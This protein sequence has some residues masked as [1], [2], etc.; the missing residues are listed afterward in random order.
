VILRAR[1]L[2]P[3][4]APPV[5]DGAVLISGDHIRFAGPWEDLRPHATGS[6]T[7]LGEVAL[8]PGLINA[9]C[10]LDYTHLAGQLKPTA[11][12]PDWIKAI[13]AAKSA[14]GIGEFSNSWLAGARQLLESG[15]TTVVNIES[16][17]ELLESCRP[18]TP[19]RVWSF[20]E[21]TGVRS[22]LPAA[23]IVGQRESL[24]KGQS[25]GRGGFG[26]SPHAPYSTSP[27]LLRCAAVIAR[28]HGWP[29]STHVA[30]SQA[31][32]DMFMYR[33]G[34]MFD[35]LESQRPMDD[36]G[37]GSPVQHLDRCGALGPDQ[38]AV[39]V[40]YLWHDDAHLLA[41][42]GASVVHCSQSHA[43]FR[44]HRF[45]RVE[46]AAAG[47]NLCL[48]TD[49]L[50]STRT[51]P[52]SHPTLSL[53][54]E[55]RA[56][57]AADAMLDPRELL[58]MTTVNPARALGRQGQL[59]ELA[60]G[61]LADLIALP[62]AGDVSHVIEAVTQHQGHVA[63]AMIDGSWSWLAPGFGG[64]ATANQLDPV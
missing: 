58:A 24:L 64:V 40:N 44:H 33:R 36:C 57:T 17:P 41:R 3:I 18:Q 63:A 60:A 42:Q 21:M 35:W 55:M 6:V 5:E 12:F 4:S 54:D 52:H 39:H 7:D 29:L 10:H 37:M 20:L 31:E 9:H 48:G 56:L 28:R 47:V 61:A 50:A 1:T 38:L 62:F 26:L 51:R 45:P 22:R 8:L 14:W 23:D 30:E 11:S 32:F 2:L 46:L 43:Y 15:T 34:P 49:S 16:V 27:E 59:G 25:A 19:L 13:M 53:F